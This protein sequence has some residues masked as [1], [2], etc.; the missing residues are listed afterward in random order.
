MSMV[1]LSSVLMNIC[2]HLNIFFIY[3]ERKYSIYILIP[4]LQELCSITGKAN[5]Q[6]CLIGWLNTLLKQKNEIYHNSKEKRRDL[7]LKNKILLF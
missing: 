7:R 1:K 5:I 6:I 4:M 3:R 2:T